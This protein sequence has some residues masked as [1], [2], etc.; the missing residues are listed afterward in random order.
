M[1]AALYQSV[2]GAGQN[3][4]TPVTG[5]FDHDIPP[6]QQAT[7]NADATKVILHAVDES[8]PTNETVSEPGPGDLN[9]LQRP[10]M[11]GDGEAIAALQQ[12]GV[13]QV[14]L[15]TGAASLPDLKKVARETGAL[16]PAGGVDCDGNGTIELAEGEPLVCNFDPNQRVEDTGLDTGIQRLL[17]ATVDTNDVALKT[18]GP[19]VI[20]D[21]VSPAVHTNIVLQ[22]TKRLE[23]DVTFK[24]P[25]LSATRA[26]EVDLEVPL[27]RRA[28]PHASATVVCRPPDP[29]EPE[30]PEL[31]LPPAP[32]AAA[33]LVALAFPPPPPPPP[34]ILEISSA[35][36][37]QTQ[38]QAQAGMVH[39]EEQQPQLAHVTASHDIEEELAF[40]RYEDEAESL[41]TPIRALGAGAVVMSFAFGF[42]MLSQEMARE[43][44]LN[45]RR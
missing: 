43:K 31:P 41:I 44:V 26:Y 45:R 4:G 23:F 35:S 28:D 22:T 33:A 11:T 1:Y 20:I 8:F 9:S 5:G 34:P 30:E 25:R 19:P 13:I 29:A 32:P 7:F 38:A 36:Q 2:T 6:G 17:E 10:D 18:S 24:C 3:L 37:S 21:K 15:S 42:L 40:A 27:E 14:G 16:A 39:Q 12:Y